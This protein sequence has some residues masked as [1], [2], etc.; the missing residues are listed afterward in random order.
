M[1]TAKS[2]SM[3]LSH[4]A[5]SLRVQSYIRHSINATL[6]HQHYSSWANARST[7][8]LR[9][10]AESNPCVSQTQLAQGRLREEEGWGGGWNWEG[11]AGQWADQP[12]GGGR[13]WNAEKVECRLRTMGRF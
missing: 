3:N 5:I 11:W 6:L 7:V 9:A 2:Q 1:A 10:L 8:G 12:E 4:L 13:G